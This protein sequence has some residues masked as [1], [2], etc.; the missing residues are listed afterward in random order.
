MFQLEDDITFQWPVEVMQPSKE[1]PGE[2]VKH[3]FTGVFRAMTADEA[4]AFDEETIADIGRK[5]DE[6]KHGPNELM[7]RVL[8]GWFSVSDAQGKETPFSPEARDRLLRYP[9]VQIALNKAWIAS[10]DPEARRKGN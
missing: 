7:K 10:H 2:F 8:V 6:R 3:V 1:K 4:K 5:P 9:W